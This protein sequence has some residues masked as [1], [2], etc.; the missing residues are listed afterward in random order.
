LPGRGERR[1]LEKKK[2]RRAQQS[3]KNH[4]AKF[5]RIG[6]NAGCHII[7]LCKGKAV[8]SE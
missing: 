8:Y 7:A 6:A 2:K 3:T 1:A 4:L 5:A